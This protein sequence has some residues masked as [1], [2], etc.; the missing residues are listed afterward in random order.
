M[1]AIT[2]HTRTRQECIDITSRVQDAVEATNIKSGLCVVFC[3]HT[4]AALAINE[5][6]DIIIHF[7]AD[8]QFMASDINNV[9]M[10]IKQG[11]A[12]IVFGSRFLNKK[13]N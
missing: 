9:I 5:N 6:A 7:D 4:T 2:V 1:D 11:S 10:P 8:G 3:P 13:S 12:D